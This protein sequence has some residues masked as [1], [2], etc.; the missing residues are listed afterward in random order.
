MLKL[1]NNLSARNLTNL[2]SS[3]QFSEKE[4]I[5]KIPEKNV[6]TIFYLVTEYLNQVILGRLSTKHIRMNKT[7]DIF[8]EFLKKEHAK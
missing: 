6:M 8:V 2:F 1:N 3:I 7:V 4:K 5:E